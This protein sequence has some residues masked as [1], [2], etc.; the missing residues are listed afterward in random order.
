[1]SRLTSSSKK[2]LINGVGW[3]LSG[4]S[5]CLVWRTLAHS[6]ASNSCCLFLERLGFV[7]E[8][9]SSYSRCHS[10]ITIT[11][12]SCTVPY[13]YQSNLVIN[14]HTPPSHRVLFKRFAHSP[15]CYHIVH[16]SRLQ[17]VCLRLTFRRHGCP[18]SHRNHR[19][20]PQRHR[21]IPEPGSVAPGEQVPESDSSMEGYVMYAG[22]NG[23]CQIG[24]GQLADAVFEQ[25]SI[26][27]ICCRNSTGP[28]LKSSLTS[29]TLS[30]REKTWRR[31]RRT[32]D[33]MTMPR[34]SLRSRG[35]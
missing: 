9:Y 2:T 19:R 3:W 27:G 25:V 35:Y 6:G 11:I 21:P 15:R 10:R 26:W 32:L 22:D 33:V 17:A 24:L 23:D 29:V 7:G 12:R 20:P 8:S 30:S 18:R 14:I 31:K 13:Y 5:R 28:P 16:C 4:V 1:M 34:N